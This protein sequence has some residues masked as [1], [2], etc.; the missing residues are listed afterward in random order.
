[1][2][3][4]S[5]LIFISIF[6]AIFTIPLAASASEEI[7]FVGADGEG[8]RGIFDYVYRLE[9][10]GINIYGIDQL[11]WD[12][13]E[14]DPPSGKG[15]HNYNWAGLDEIIRKIESVNGRT[16]ITIVSSSTWATRL[17]Q[18]SR[19]ASPPENDS[20]D[21][22]KAFVQALVERYDNDGYLDM[23]GLKY[24]HLY[25]QI[26]DEAENPSSWDGTVEEY[27]RLL[28][29]SK[30]SARLANPDVK[31]FTFSPNLG[32]FFDHLSP[33]E[34]QNR[35][36]IL[37]QPDENFPEKKKGLRKK[38]SKKSRKINFVK[39]VFEAED[40]YDFIAVQYNYHYTG[41]SGIVAVIRKFS[42]KPIWV[43]DAAS[44]TLLGRH[45][46]V[47]EEYSEEQ[48]PYLS[49]REIATI[50]TSG[51]H[52]KYKEV[53][54]WWETEKARTT[55]KKI[56]TAASL[57]IEHVFLQFIMDQRAKPRKNDSTGVN[58]W[59]FSGLLENNGE[60]RAVCYTIKLFHEKFRNFSSVEDLTKRE[61]S[62]SNW[63]MHYRFKVEGKTLDVLWTDGA[64]KEY[65]VENGRVL[66]TKIV[67][68]K[69]GWPPQSEVIKRGKVVVSRS[70]II[71]E[72]ES[73]HSLKMF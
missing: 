20:W 70:P 32:D 44:S 18:R 37:D 73:N 62:P 27:L 54:E 33:A 58:P 46:R 38:D 50:L 49:E 67:E 69:N 17:K 36:R 57:G 64:E 35:L 5:R 23:P 34:I 63:L 31:I 43:V 48:Y 1:M 22:Y 10:T 13:I 65:P 40:T 28:K 2:R 12:F 66:V 4:T 25:Y 24:A 68:R 6:L 61:G 55:F 21:D 42:S 9:N 72:N 59:N 56:I 3:Y 19:V 51:G 47:K 30:E 71:V 60:L 14:P 15:A 52:A 26:L 45:Q 53:R 7:S 11:W 41:L 8:V 16:H 39:T 29:A